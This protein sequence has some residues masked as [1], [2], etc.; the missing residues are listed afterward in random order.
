MSIEKS[1]NEKFVKTF[2]SKK[3]VYT[4]SLRTKEDDEKDLMLV[5]SEKIKDNGE[6]EF[7][8]NKIRIYS[9]SLDNFFKMIDE[10]KEK[11]KEMKK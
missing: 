4:F 7:A 8:A 6:N 3:R 9:E 10:L 1:K 11:V 2:V 5:M